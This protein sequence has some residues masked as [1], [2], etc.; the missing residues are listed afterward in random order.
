MDG[1]FVVMEGFFAEITTE[2]F[3]LV[4]TEGFFLAMTEGF[5]SVMLDGF[6]LMLMGGFFLWP[7]TAWAAS[8][9]TDTIPR[10]PHRSGA[11][12]AAWRTAARKLEHSL[13]QRA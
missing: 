4:M 10:V 7:W 3:F 1:F 2:G 13:H 6:F 9:L 11:A 12:A 8:S 5:F